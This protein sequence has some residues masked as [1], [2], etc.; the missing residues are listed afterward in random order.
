MVHF[1]LWELAGI[2]E[3]YQNP[4]F[5]L[6]KSYGFLQCHLNRAKYA[7]EMLDYYIYVIFSITFVA[8]PPIKW[9]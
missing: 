9:R 7:N 3:I 4:W 8:L 1:L 6:G 5:E 2:M